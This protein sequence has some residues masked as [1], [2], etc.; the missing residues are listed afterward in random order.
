MDPTSSLPTPSQ[1][2]GHSTY[3][4][5]SHAR[6]FNIYG[7]VFNDIRGGVHHHAERSV[8]NACILILALVRRSNLAAVSFR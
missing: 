4:I 7:A 3:S 5:L 1:P 8:G 6:D 2:Q